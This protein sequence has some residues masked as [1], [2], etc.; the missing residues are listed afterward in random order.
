MIKHIRKHI[1]S[2]RGIQ[3]TYSEKINNE[4]FKDTYVT[5][6]DDDD[7]DDNES[8]CIREFPEPIRY[9][10]WYVFKYIVCFEEQPPNIVKD[11]ADFL[12]P[13][14]YKEETKYLFIP[15]ESEYGKAVILERI[16]E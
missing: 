6:M 8:Y 13:R 7:D 11:M 1:T 12:N 3:Q 2:I 5:Y 14:S 9:N 4:I 16:R 15:V 10:P